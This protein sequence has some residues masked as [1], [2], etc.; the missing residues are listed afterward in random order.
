[1]SWWEKLDSPT[2]EVSIAALFE[3]RLPETNLGAAPD[4][5]AVIDNLL[6][7][8]FPAMTSLTH[9]QSADRMRATSTTSRAPTSAASPTSATSP[10]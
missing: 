4:L 5:G 8:G 1:M 10:K 2:G 3:G 7:P 6:R 9:E